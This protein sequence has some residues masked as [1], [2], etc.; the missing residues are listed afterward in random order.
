MGIP[1]VPIFQGWMPPEVGS[2]PPFPPLSRIEESPPRAGPGACVMANRDSKKPVRDAVKPSAPPRTAKPPQPPQA[3][4]QKAAQPVKKEE[5]SRWEDE[6]GAPPK[7]SQGRSKD[8]DGT[9]KA[10]PP[11]EV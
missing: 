10:P 2:V 1:T 5:I 4:V 3:P 7:G 9:G 11:R 8:G 6:G